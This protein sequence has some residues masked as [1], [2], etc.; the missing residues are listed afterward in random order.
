MTP[1]VIAAIAKKEQT[2]FHRAMLHHGMSLMR[3][4]RSEMSKYYSDWDIHNDVY[5][6]VRYPDDEDVKNA[7]RNKPVKMVVPNTFAQVMTFSSFL[8][9]LFNQNR[10]FFECVPTGDEDYGEKQKDIETVIQRDVQ[11]NKWNQLLFNVLLN[12]GRFGPGI[13][14]VEW[15]R[16]V[17]NIYV[18]PEPQVI[19]VGGTQSVIRGGSQWEEYVKYEGNIVTSVDPYRFFPDTR[20]ALADYNRGEFCAAEQEYSVAALRKME[21]AGEVAGV[22]NIENFGPNWESMRG[23]V[24]RTQMPQDKSTGFIIGPSQSEGT[25][26]V[27]K[28]QVWIVPSH[29]TIEGEK[30]LGPEEFPVLYHL[31]YANDNRVIKCEPCYWWHNEFSW[32]VGQFTPDMHQTVNMGLADL[33]YA[34]QDVITWHIN[35]RITDV[36]RNMRGRL[37]IDPSGVTDSVDGEGDI[38]LRKGMGKA[39]I[40]RFVK[41]LNTVDVTQGHLQDADILGKIMEVVTGVNGNAMGQ[42]NSGR[43]SAQESRT[44]TAGASGRMKM[45]GHLLWDDMLAPTGR[46][47]LSNSRQSLAF[48]TF[49]RA[50]GA[51][52]TPERYAAFRGTPQEI[53]AGDDYFTFDSTLSSEKGFIAQSLQELLTAIIANPIAA[54]QLNLNPQLILEEMQYLRGAGSMKRFAFSNTAPLA[55]QPPITSITPAV[56]KLQAQAARGGTAA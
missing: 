29:F 48:D 34:L 25:R 5:K 33:I 12:V 1:D 47:M 46:K 4:S 18:T 20:F 54:Q 17:S 7:K 37:I 39:G 9:L 16:D 19:N 51:N 56:A 11:K 22:D 15:T 52:A 55:V 21:V 13:T 26:L 50:C 38:Y 24:T 32:N 23:G 10:T 43:R 36:R 31:W 6:G 8:F 30:K 14:N 44:V 45:H 40:D 27:T 3:L 28:M 41:Q 2:P 49:Q 35:A 42:Y 53:V